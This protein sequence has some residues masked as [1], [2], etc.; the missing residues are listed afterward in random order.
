MPLNEPSA[1]ELKTL[2]SL[3]DFDGQRVLEI[4]TGDGRLAWPFAPA[5]A[6]W[7]ALDPDAGELGLAASHLRED[8]FANLRLLI[9]DG[10]ALSFP[11]GYFDI[12]F[13]TWSLC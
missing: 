2:Q 3:A 5:A 11:A 13:L 4:G 6:Q 8:S 7:V 9:G 12:V 1:L 10:R